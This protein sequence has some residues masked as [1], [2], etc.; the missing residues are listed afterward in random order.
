M[1]MRWHWPPENWWGRGP[2]PRR[3]RCRPPRA[4]SSTRASCSA[5]V[6]RFQ[7]FS[8]STTMSPTLRRGFSDEIGSWKIICISGRTPA[9][10]LARAASVRSRA[11]EADRARGRG[12]QLHDRPPGGGLAAAGLADEAEGLARQHV[13]ADVGD[14]VDLQPG[15]A[16]R[17]LDDEVLDPQQGLALAVAGGRCRCRPSVLLTGLVGGRRRGGG[18]AG[19][20]GREPTVTPS[21]WLRASAS[22]PS[23]VP[24]GN[25]QRKR[26]SGSPAATRGGASSRHRGCT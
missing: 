8:G 12:G 19:R 21:A 17:E 22:A 18:R 16:D 25:Q 4:S 10:V 20:R 14:G 1:E 11:V 5:A 15:A 24:T 7:I 23:G 6:P 9:Q 26:W 3:R 2:A 13:E